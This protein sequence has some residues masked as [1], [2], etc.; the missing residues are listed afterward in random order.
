MQNKEIIQ[1]NTKSFPEIWATLS[2]D[3]KDELRLKF[4]QRKCCKTRQAISYWVTGQR[5][6][7]PLVRE[8]IAG[9]VSKSIGAKCY[10][11]TLFPSR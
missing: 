10:A 8:T 3:E 7:S 1:T 5:R 9:I 2:E 11:H 6:P 4:Y